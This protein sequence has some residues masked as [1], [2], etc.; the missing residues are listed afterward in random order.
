MDDTPLTAAYDGGVVDQAAPSSP[1]AVA[2]TPD[3][4]PVQPT[5]DA[6]HSSEA[7]T[8]CCVGSAKIF[9]I[10]LEPDAVG[11]LQDT[12]ACDHAIDHSTQRPTSMLQDI[13]EPIPMTLLLSAKTLGTYILSVASLICIVENFTQH[14]PLGSV[15]RYDG[16]NPPISYLQIRAIGILSTLLFIVF[17]PRMLFQNMGRRAH[18]SLL[19]RRILILF[20]PTSIPRTVVFVIPTVVNVAATV[21]LFVKFSAPLGV[22]VVFLS[23]H[24]ALCGQIWICST[25]GFCPTTTSLVNLAESA[26]KDH[27]LFERASDAAVDT[28]RLCDEVQ[29][30]LAGVVQSLRV[31]VLPATNPSWSFAPT[32]RKRRSF[33][34]LWIVFSSFVGVFAISIYLYL[35]NDSNTKELWSAFLNPCAAA[36]VSQT[37]TL[38]QVAS[39]VQIANYTLAGNCLASCWNGIGTRQFISPTDCDSFFDFASNP[40]M[41]GLQFNYDRIKACNYTFS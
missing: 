33:F 26:S 5:G 31:V 27:N 32:I 40:Q 2:A 16:T 23:T 25:L 34:A 20:E 7:D 18:S 41:A 37:L 36:C 4:P 3:A 6:K 39:N 17:L 12:V 8:R 24:A 28:N 10:P 14:L 15:S 19:A 13:E 22:Y 9:S 38:L 1:T 29:S 21:F 35:T 30:R 11:Q